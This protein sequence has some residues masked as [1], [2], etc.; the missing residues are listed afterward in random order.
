[1]WWRDGRKRE[2]EQVDHHEERW[3]GRLEGERNRPALPPQALM[4]SQSML[5]LR[6]VTTQQQGS[7]LVSVA[8]ITTKDHA[9]ISSQGCA[10][11]APP[12]NGCG[13]LES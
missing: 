13:F 2:A 10:E 1:M 8:H 6:S 11:L 7:V 5:L 3:D 4:K 12:F 9:E